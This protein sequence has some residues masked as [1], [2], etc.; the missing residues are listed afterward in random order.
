MPSD[1]LR[2]FLYEFYALAQD[3]AL[4]FYLSSHPLKDATHFRPDINSAV[5]ELRNAT[6]N[7][8]CQALAQS[9]K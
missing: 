5:S 3:R 2:T 4:N 8:R 6:T 9:H 1:Q 7:K